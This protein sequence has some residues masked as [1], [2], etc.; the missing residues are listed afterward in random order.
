MNYEYPPLGGGGGVASEKIAG[1]LSAQYRYDITVITAGVGREIRKTTDDRGI[2]IIRIP[3]AAERKHRSSASLKFMLNYVI[4]SVGY[5]LCNRGKLMQYD[6]IHTYFGIPTGL[7]GLISAWIL[8]LPHVLTL[9]G[10]ELYQQPLEVKYNDKKWMNVLLKFVTEHSDSVTAI[11]NDT[12]Q[13]AID[14]LKTDK[15]IKV[16]TLG[17]DPPILKEPG[18]KKY[19]EKDEWPVSLISVSRLVG[20]KGYSYLLEA[21]AGIDK[22]RWELMLLGDGPEKKRLE[23]KAEDLR[24]ADRVTFTDYVSEEEKFNLLRQADLF[25]LPTLHEGLGLVYYEAMYCGLAIVTTNNGGQNDFL[26]NEENALLVPAA[27]TDLLRAAID[28]ALNDHSWRCKT[29][30][31]NKECI[32]GLYIRNIISE[33]HKLFTGNQRVSL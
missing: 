1:E 24:I 8:G 21:L 33:Y 11:S 22:S 29:G 27:N 15:E 2:E 26:K 20:R 30:K 12:R 7:S 23:K 28:R 31:A 5:V 9:I 19:K 6:C 17:F 10:G 14:I 25:V 18:K 4:K 16:I 32:A 13:A 3:C